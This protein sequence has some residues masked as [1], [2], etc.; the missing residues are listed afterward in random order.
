[1]KKFG[2]IALG[3]VVAIGLYMVGFYN[4]LVTSREKVDNQW[5]QVQTSY[6]RRFDLIPNLVETVKGV[7]AQEQK[8]FGDIADARTRYAGAKTPEQQLEATNQLESSVSRLL[9]IVENYPQLRSSESFQTLMAQLEGTENRIN[10]E[11]QR[12]N[13]TVREYNMVT[14][15]FPANLLARAFGFTERAYFEAAQTAQTA[16]EVKF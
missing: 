1:M 2:L 10:V 5:A 14:K 11:R 13:D 3:L 6:Q 4:N 8:V 7:A 16:P 9:V 15:R 12:F